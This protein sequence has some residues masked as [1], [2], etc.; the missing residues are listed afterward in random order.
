VSASE[1]FLVTGALGCI[2]AWTVRALAREGTPVVEFDLGRDR[3]RLEQIMT[4]DELGSVELVA[5]D[6]T[7]L[8]SLERTLGD[9][10]ITNVVHLA[11]LQ[12][13]FCRADPPLGAA[14]N[15]VGTVNV[16][17][18]VKRRGIAPAPVVYTSSIGAFGADDEDPATHRLEES[19][20][21]HPTTHYGVYKK[22]NEGTARIYALDDGIPSIGLRP[23]TVY[24]VGR[25]QGM[26]STPTSA[27]AAAVLG[28][29]YEITFSGTTLYQYAE[30]VAATLLAASRSGLTGA[31]VF[32]LGGSSVDIA[33]WIEAIEEVVPEAAGTIT[34]A[35]NQLPFP[36]E[37]AHDALAAVGP[38][39]VTPYRDGIAATV[40][41]LRGLQADG[42]LVGTQ[43]GLPAEAPSPA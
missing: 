14:V 41:I 35:S 25:D 4:V 5:G 43:Q 20:E 42:R 15:V 8:P 17:E 39:P 26:T 34:A 36:S 12:V 23:M 9:R 28:R 30:D 38:V 3:R 33:D 7:D 16:F 2:G 24:G 11:A 32:N 13:P 37:I 19:T 27:I 31:S 18:A 1:R 40:G 29:P 6:I 22:A 10:G 21:G